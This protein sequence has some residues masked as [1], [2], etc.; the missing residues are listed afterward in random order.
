MTNIKQQLVSNTLASKVTSG[1]GN[2]RKYIVVHETGNTKKGANAQAHANLQSNGNSRQA[3]W[4]YSVDEKQI[5]Q[6]FADSYVCWHAGGSGVYNR[7][8]IGVEIC[9]NSDGNFRGAVNNAVELVNYLMKKHNIPKSRVITHK[10]TSGK[11]CPTNLLSGS[12]GITWNQFKS[13]IGGNSSVTTNGVLKLWD[14]SPAVGVCQEKLNK[15]GYPLVVDNSYGK[16]TE[17][18]VRQF[19]RDNSLTV[20]GLYGSDTER[21]LDEVLAI[22]E[23]ELTMS[24]YN[25]LLK[26]IE[27]LETKMGTDRD[28]SSG[29]KEDWK[30][31][32]DKGL[33]NG[34]RPSHLVTREQ[35]SAVMHRYS[36]YNF[37]SD[38]AKKDLVEALKKAY[39]TKV[40]IV[41]HS[42]KVD[43][44]SEHEIINHLISLVNRT[45]NPLEK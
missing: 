10:A 16:A 33:M 18:A 42:E 30:W 37:L 26:K 2:T 31:A 12:K 22:K 5:I 45:F 40:F 15:V 23:G 8:G 25:E 7:E 9:V 20:D 38:T 36:D 27:A 41:D 32:D 21:K 43:E 17:S 13:M 4:H 24:Q 39:E 29:F 19:Q 28:V 1:R 35:L 34:E 44:M 6:S 11:N 3:S 14:V